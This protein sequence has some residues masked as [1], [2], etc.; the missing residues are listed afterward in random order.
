MLR[1]SQIQKPQ[2][3]SR[4]NLSRAVHLHQRGELAQAEK[5]YIAVLAAGQSHFEALHGLGVL[6]AQQGRYPEAFHN[7]FAAVKLQPGNVG[8]LSNLGIVHAGLGRFTEA[9]ACYD[10]ALALKPEFPEA[11]ANRG[12]VLRSLERPEEALESYDRAIALKPGVADIYNNRSGALRDLNRIQEALESC[13]RALSLNPDHLDAL[14]NRGCALQSLDRLAEAVA[15]FDNALAVNPQFIPALIN[16]GHALKNLGY[17]HQALVSYDRALAL[18]SD[19][20]EASDGKGLALM[21]LGRLEEAKKAIEKAI[22]FAPRRAG[23]YYNLTTIMRMSPGDWRLHAMQG[24]AKDPLSLADSE[25]MF[26]Q[27]ALAKALAD[28]GDHERSFQRLEHGNSLKRKQIAYEETPIL[29]NLASTKTAFSDKMMRRRAGLGDPSDVPIFIVGMP[30]SGTTLVEQILAAH[31]KVF[32]AGETDDFAKAM[33][34]CGGSIAEALR[35][36]ESV[37]HVPPDGWRKLGARYIE[38]VRAFAPNAERIVNKLPDNFR[39]IG[40]IRLAFPNARIIH[41]RRDPIDTCLSCYSHLFTG[42]IPYAYELRELGRY[43]KAYEALT[44]HWRQILPRDGFLEVQYEQLVTDFEARTRRIISYCGLDWDERC[45]AFYQAERQVRTASVVQV[46]QP[47]YTHS[48]GRWRVYKRF[49]GPLI[50]EL[51]QNVHLGDD[52]EVL[53]QSKRMPKLRAKI[54]ERIWRAAPKTQAARSD[55]Q[56]GE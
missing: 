37:S 5:E 46:R 31:P 16:R 40:F 44:S 35:S 47:I 9:L 18:K 2:P 41:T 20:A 11:L 13:E 43:Y 39:L 32:A 54:F 14:N 38:R 27:F 48:I 24:L 28:I 23:F 45:L 6:Q 4:L 33:L 53:P 22:E 50:A 1:Q 36:P 25:Q 51:G 19:C 55:S 29:N 52:L 3:G 15:C 26:L 49:L 42:Y 17:A 34:S 30:R 8:A 21:E 10:G 56:S 7:L 12:D